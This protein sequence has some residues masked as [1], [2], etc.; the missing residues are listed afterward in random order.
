MASEKRIGD[1]PLTPARYACAMIRLLTWPTYGTWL[2]GPGRGWVDPG[3]VQT[4]DTLPE[5]DATLSSHRR[6]SLKWPAVTLDNDQQRL[7]LD[8][9]ARV[10]ALRGFVPRLAVAAPDHVHLML[11]ADERAD[12]HRMIQLT[13]GALSRLLTVAAG[14]APAVSAAGDA[15]AFHKWWTRQY[16]FRVIRDVSVN[17]A[18]REVLMAHARKDATV[19]SEWPD[20][21][22]PPRRR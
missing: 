21:T 3:A 16:S 19:R 7:I 8:D 20:A 6:S 17:D 5:P 11:A 22:P 9:I 12:L 10:G 15:L 1:G 13:K 2:P 18:V 14:D 4:D